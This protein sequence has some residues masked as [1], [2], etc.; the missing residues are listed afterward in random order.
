MLRD[1]YGLEVTTANA[2][3][4]TAIDTYTQDWIGY[5][6]RLRTIFDAA[7]ADAES[8]LANAQAA[9]VHMALEAA[10]GF[11]AARHYIKRARA[12]VRD[13]NEREKL[14]VAAVVA[15]WRG[16]T[17]TAMATLRQLTQKFPEDIAAAKWGQYHAF[18]LGRSAEVLTF[19]EDTLPAH[20]LTA[21]AWGMRAFGFEQCSRL[22]EAEDA[23]RKALSLK[24]AEP[25][26]QHAIAHV[27][28]TQGRLDDGIEFLRDYAHTWRDRSVFI[29]EH[30]YWHLALL[31]LDRDESAQALDIFDNHLWGEWPEFAQEQIGA[32]AAL[33][34]MELRGV[35]VGDRW[36]PV[37]D[38]V[39]ARWHEHILPF[40]DMHFVYALAR[41]GH[42]AEARAFLTSL[43]RHGERDPSGIWDSVASP[44][45]TG[46]V[47]YAQGKYEQTL[48]LITPLLPRLHLIGGSHVQRD[49][50][51]QTW[52]DASLKA[53]HCSAVEDL[54]TRR[55]RERPTVAATRRQ[56]DL[57]R[58]GKSRTAAP[59]NDGLSISA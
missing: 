55:N 46:L 29:R 45:A 34:R 13:A 43:A 9:A 44:L 24:R 5:G 26:A 59:A 23:G 42:M 58:R 57:A 36:A 50:F 20:K 17:A 30:N 8:A 32:I 27:M 21:E 3:T 49:V 35:G 19:A 38:N 4:I 40:H 56:L 7:D 2:A 12:V 1:A 15:W 52:I 11:A 54:L 39:L 6:T 18:N 37:V 16:D 22:R 47:A 48:A 31:H 10:T 28:D 41:G 33:W 51:I 14:F 53:G 25:W